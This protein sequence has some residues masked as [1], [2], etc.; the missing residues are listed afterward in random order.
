VLWLQPATRQ[1]RFIIRIFDA[2]RLWMLLKIIYWTA[3]FS[4]HL[5]VGLHQVYSALH[6]TIY[7]VNVFGATRHLHLHRVRENGS[8]R[9]IVVLS[10]LFDPAGRTKH[11]YEV[12]GRTNKLKSND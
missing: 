12:A 7:R 5:H 11:N 3:Y 1:L 6:C 9:P 8:L 2:L 4:E 10:N